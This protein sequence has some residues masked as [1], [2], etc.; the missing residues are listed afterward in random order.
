[1]LD[2][3]AAGIINANLGLNPMNN[4]EVLIINVPPLTEER[5][6]ELSK[7]ARAEGESARV[8]IRNARK[9]A[10]D[11]LKSA[12]DEGMSE[13]MQKTGEGQV[14][15]LTNTYIAKVEDMLNAKEADIMT[16]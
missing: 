12:K 5:R 9:D 6:T 10:N 4:G 11:L 7:R 1:M 14:Q 13:D 2:E 3:I 15:D 8:S 16:I